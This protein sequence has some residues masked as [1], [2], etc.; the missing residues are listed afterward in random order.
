MA[1]TTMPSGG[2]AGGDQVGRWGRAG[3]GRPKRVEWPRAVT[4]GKR[5]LGG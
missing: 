5:G 1:E 3:G 2:G 4:A